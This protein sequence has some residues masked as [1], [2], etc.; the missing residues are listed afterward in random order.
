MSENV[1][2][3]VRLACWGTHVDLFSI[4]PTKHATGLTISRHELSESVEYF[5]TY[6]KL[7]YCWSCEVT[8]RPK[9]DTEIM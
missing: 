7:D 6:G 3:C 4:S 1:D 5:E 2:S 8:C 9:K